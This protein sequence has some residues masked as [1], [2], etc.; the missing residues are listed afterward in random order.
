MAWPMNVR[1]SLGCCWGDIGP[2]PELD[3]HRVAVA[4]RSALAAGEH[5]VQAQ[6]A[7]GQLVLKDDPV[8]PSC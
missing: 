6:G 1:R 2:L 3:D 4:G 5:G 7:Q 8:A